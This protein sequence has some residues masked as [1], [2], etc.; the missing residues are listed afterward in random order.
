MRASPCG[1]GATSW[2]NTLVADAREVRGH[3]RVVEAGVAALHVGVGEPRAGL[4]EELGDLDVGRQAACAQRL[5]VVE[6]GIAA[7]QALEQGR[8]EA[9]LQAGA[10]GRAHQA[11]PGE[12]AQPQAPVGLGQAVERVDERRPACRRRSEWRAQCRARRDRRSPRRNGRDRWSGWAR[13]VSV[14]V[15]PAVLRPPAPGID[16]YAPVKSRPGAAWPRA[17]PARGGRA[18]RG[19]AA[20]GRRRPSRAAP[21]C[22]RWGCP[23]RWRAG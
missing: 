13:P 9:L 19:R 3:L 8:D 18:S 15:A 2:P 22:G 12:D 20:W 1:C 14:V 23:C 21:R 17:H 4:Q 6:V 5:G 10:V 7:A 16:A 11:E